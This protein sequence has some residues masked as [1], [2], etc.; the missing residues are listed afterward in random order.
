MVINEGAGRRAR[1]PAGMLSHVRP[2]DLETKGL[3]LGGEKRVIRAGHDLPNDA[4]CRMP[5]PAAM[6]KIPPAGA[7]EP[8]RM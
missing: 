1:R 7:A 4:A 5:D 2:L 8:A 6:A 3:F